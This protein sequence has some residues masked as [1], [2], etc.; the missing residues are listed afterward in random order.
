MF[1]ERWQ[2]AVDELRKLIEFVESLWRNASENFNPKLWAT[3]Y[4][5]LVDYISE[6]RIQDTYNTQ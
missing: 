6:E 3:T 5:F 1:E 2:F 4:Q